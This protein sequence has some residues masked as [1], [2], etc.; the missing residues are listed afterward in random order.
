MRLSASHAS[1]SAV[2]RLLTFVTRIMSRIG[3][4][5]YADVHES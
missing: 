1:G 3:S 5:L 4:H 2:L